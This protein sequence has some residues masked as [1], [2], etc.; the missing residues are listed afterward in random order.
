MKRNYFLL[1]LALLICASMFTSCNEAKKEQ[2]K[3]DKEIY[4]QLYS[5]RDDIRADY[6]ATIAALAEIGFTG[7]EAFGY[8]NG[9]WFG[10]SPTEF[11]RSI[12]DVDMTLISSHVG[13][14]L[15]DNPADTDWDELWAWWDTAIQAHKEAGITYM[16]LPY[17]NPDQLRTVENVQAYVDYFNKIG[18]RTNAAGLR[19][20]YHNHDFE[21][22]IEVDGMPVLDYMIQNT[23]PAKVFFQLDVYWVMEGGYDV[24]DY[25][26]KYPGR[27]DL[28]HIKDE[29]ELGE[30]GLMDFEHI[31]NNLDN[32]GARYMV[33]EVER[34]SEGMTPLESVGVSFDFLNDAS[35]FRA[36]YSK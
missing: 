27:F 8:N 36:S 35:W 29:M 31:F 16:I 14:G 7:V 25:F 28:L 32:S 19:F 18:E 1:T 23:D 34:Y 30:S 9:Q 26:N 10:M 22:T 6:S 5:V 20:G 17:I 4:I 11:K 24:V 12:E 15:P 3:T 21:L 2:S 13:R 33:V